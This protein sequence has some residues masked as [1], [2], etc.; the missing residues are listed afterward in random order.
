MSTFAFTAERLA[1]HTTGVL[2]SAAFVFADQTESQ[3]WPNG[4][5]ISARLLM[6]HGQ[7]VALRI[8]AAH[9]FGPLLAA[10]LLGMEPDSDEARASAG[11]AIGEL[12]NMLAGGL[13]AEIFGKGV[14]SKITIPKVTQE[15]RAEHLKHLEGVTCRIA[16]ITEEGFRLDASLALEEAP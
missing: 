8:C 14:I 13:A 2:E 6:E 12:A 5:A 11:D 9:E 1:A 16:L 3:D 10:N 7:K 15:T 4:G